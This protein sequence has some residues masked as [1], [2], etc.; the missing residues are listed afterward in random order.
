MSCVI[1]T[2]DLSKKFRNTA[3]LDRLIDE[4]QQGADVLEAGATQAQRR[5]LGRLDRPGHA[6]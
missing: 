4:A 2:H 6:S 3:V 1:R 5:G